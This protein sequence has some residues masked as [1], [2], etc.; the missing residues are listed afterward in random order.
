MNLQH[1]IK[2]TSNGIVHRLIDL[3]EEDRSRIKEW[4]GYRTPAIWHVN[5]TDPYTYYVAVTD[6]FQGSKEFPD[7]R[8]IYFVRGFK[9][10]DID[11]KPSEPTIMAQQIY[12]FVNDYIDSISDFE[13]PDR[14]KR[15]TAAERCSEFVGYCAARLTGRIKR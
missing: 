8:Q 6:Y 9:D 12:G 13:D 11:E 2:D 14:A 3:D 1:Q 7:C 15:K 5:P 4:V 10:L